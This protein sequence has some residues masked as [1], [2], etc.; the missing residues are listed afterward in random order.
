MD[1]RHYIKRPVAIQ[2]Q[3]ALAVLVVISIGCSNQ[4][5][6]E[7]GLNLQYQ[8]AT[9]DLAKFKKE[10]AREQKLEFNTVDIEGRATEEQREKIVE[11]Q[12][13]LKELLNKLIAINPPNEG[14]RFEL[15]R[16]TASMGDHAKSMEMLK[17]L[18]PEDVPGYPPAHFL[19]AKVNFEKQALSGQERQSNLNVVLQHLEHILSRKEDDPQANLLKAQ[20]LTLVARFG[21]AYEVYEVLCETNPNFYREMVALNKQLK[22]EE[23]NP[24]L[25]E[26]ALTSFLALA[27]DEEIQS[28]NNRW[29]V[30]ETGI[31]KT[32]QG[33]DRFQDAE[34][35]L[36]ELIAHYEADP[37]GGP[38]RVFL[39]GLIADT[40]VLWAGKF[41]GP[42]ANFDSLPD[43]TLTEIINLNE[44]AYRNRSDN[45]LALQNLTRLSLSSNTEIASQAKAVYNPMSD[46]NAPA[47]VLNQIANH[48]LINKKFSEAIRYYERAREKAPRD[49][50]ILNNLAYSYLVATEGDFNPERGLQLVNEAIR[51]L[52]QN[53]PEVERAKFLHTKA[54]A[55]KLMDRLQEAIV[56]YEQSLK[57]RPNHMDT[58]RSLI[59]C[60]NGLNKLPPELY[61]SRLAEI[62]QR[63]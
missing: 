37:K 62:E 15:A 53:L 48:K 6:V 18:S 10:L 47:E 56:A 54:T 9:A 51:F 49:P 13:N 8:Q 33:L 31:T 44:K 17:E 57:A 50:S 43:A 52:P 39:Q 36:S 3:L 12:Q 27:D 55:F 7:N 46:I 58:L 29:I 61:V 2:I 22:R 60:Y 4:K 35:R 5:A 63:N 23:R 11:L 26:K 30:T 41:A 25:F 1:M 14:Y 21:E 45:S 19:L 42:N 40:Y 16:L 38:R 28:D 34:T 20:T 32:L 24:P 59:E